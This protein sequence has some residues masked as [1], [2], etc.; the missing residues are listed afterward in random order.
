MSDLKIELG[1]PNIGTCL[2]CMICAHDKPWGVFDS[3]TGAAVCKD[4]RDKARAE[5][6]T[7]PPDSEEVTATHDW[8]TSLGGIQ[9][10]HPWKIRF[11]RKDAM[12]IGLWRVDDGWKAMLIHHEHAA[13]C[14]VRG[15]ITRADV[16][17]LLAA[18]GIKE[19][20][21]A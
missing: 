6:L 12:P 1:P 17:R 20:P 10:V 13:S 19:Q 5:P 15:L 2:P 8:L 9:E 14:I 11:D 16:L 21:H 4:C 3:K 7:P 18:L